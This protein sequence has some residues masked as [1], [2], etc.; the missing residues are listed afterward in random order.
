MQ[1]FSKPVQYNY[2]QFSHHWE[3]DP[4]KPCEVDAPTENL[5]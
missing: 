2:S 3:R 5:P 1:E 4:A